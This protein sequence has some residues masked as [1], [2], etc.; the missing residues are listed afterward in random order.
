MSPTPPPDLALAGSPRDAPIDRVLAA[1]DAAGKSW[2][3]TRGRQHEAQCPAHEDTR[4]SLGVHDS[5]ERVALYC[6][7]GCHTRDVIAALGLR[8][9]DLF[10]HADE[11]DLAR[12]AYGPFVVHRGYGKRF[13]QHGDTGHKV[14]YH[15]DR[16]HAAVTAGEPV[17]L[18]EGEEDVHAL[19]AE[20]VTATTAPQ[21]ARS[22]PRADLSPLVGAHVVLVPD[23][24]DA[25]AT[26]R[27]DALRALTP[28]AA[29]LSV[30]TVRAGKDVSDHLAAGWA[31]VDLNPQPTLFRAPRSATAATAATAALPEPP[32][33]DNDPFDLHPALTHV[34]QAAR[35]R[36]VSP[37]A[38][39]GCVL[40]RA[41]A[42]VEP[43]VTLPPV[44][45]TRASLNLIIAIVA[46]SGVGKGGAHGCAADLLPGLDTFE[47]GVG[48]GEGI[49]HAYMR[50][51]TKDDTKGDGV[52]G[53]TLDGEQVRVR[54]RALLTVAEVDQLAGVAARRG[55]T[56]LP[57]LRSAWSGETLGQLT[58]DA[59]RRLH[60]PAHTYRACLVVGVQPH[61]A[62][63]LLDD[64]DGGTTQRVL[65][66]TATDPDVSR[67]LD[68]IPDWPGPLDWQPPPQEK[69]DIRLPGEL[70]TRLRELRVAVL[71]GDV[72]PVDTHLAL[73]QLKVAAALALLDTAR[74]GTDRLTVDMDDWH[75]AGLIVAQSSRVRDDLARQAAVEAAQRAH[76]QGVADGHRQVVAGE[77]VE[78]A[79]VAR[80]ADRVRRLLNRGALSQGE[81]RRQT[82]S[83]D[84]AHLRPAIDLLV[85]QGRARV[86][87]A[88]GGERVE[89]T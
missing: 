53:L 27:E 2:R 19:E 62:G 9:R 24:D 17:Y 8:E 54:T 66:S 49:A 33:V 58:A 75:V 86:A 74:R 59:T 63:V 11:H 12:Y 76:A 6:Q 36:L 84:R 30:A 56:V 80:V 69:W 85:E 68:D 7:A 45:A 60:V 44:V 1:L 57:I 5:G 38:T 37:W 43:G 52:D 83:R 3:R 47:A 78:D 64:A 55:S 23:A 25:G 31:V 28:T 39:L 73:V 29:S 21:G 20:G 65:W 82:A 79:A 35:S 46:P 15:L 26:W 14:L 81:L 67:N 42:A 89:P 71:V 48:S 32:G 50:R 10:A 87:D 13:R 77:V 40:A 51:A 41:V 34:R 88:E 72:E 70:W 61:R 18:V 16:V 22:L 4:P